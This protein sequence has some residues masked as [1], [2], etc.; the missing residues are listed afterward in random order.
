MVYVVF[1]RA[2]L[3]AITTTV[4][5]HAPPLQPA[6]SGLAVFLPC[7]VGGFSPHPPFYRPIRAMGRAVIRVRATGR[8]LTP[9]MAAA[10]R[11]P[12]MAVAART[13]GVAA[14]RTPT[15]LAAAAVRTLGMAAVVARA[16]AMVHADATAQT[17]CA[18][19]QLKVPD[20]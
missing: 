10:A 7:R 4:L 14:V 12:G 17:N 2:S 15:L 9:D 18:M 20:D 19:L 1:F 13:P 11:I 6:G 5:F 3:H 8:R 16:L